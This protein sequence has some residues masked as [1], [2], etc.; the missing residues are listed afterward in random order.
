MSLFSFARLGFFLLLLVGSDTRRL[1]SPRNNKICFS[2]QRYQPASGFHRFLSKHVKKKTLYSFHLSS[3]SHEPLSRFSPVVPLSAFQFPALHLHPPTGAAHLPSRYKRSGCHGKSVKCRCVGFSRKR[4]S[5]GRE[6][7]SPLSP[8]HV[9]VFQ[10]GLRTREH[11]G[12]SR[13]H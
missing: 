9:V 1:S 5:P 4:L 8:P 2:E 12:L 10:V 3:A 6:L 11:S 7:S 13:Y